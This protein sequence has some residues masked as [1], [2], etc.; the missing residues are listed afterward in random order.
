MAEEIIVK[1][2]PRSEQGSSAARRIRLEG[3]LPAVV[4]GEGKEAQSIVLNEHDFTQLLHHHA[5]EN[6]IITLKIGK[7]ADVKV[8]L[9]D[10]QHHPVSGNVMHADF[11]EISMTNKLQLA[12]PIELVGDPAGVKQQGG[13][14]EH[15]LRELEVECLPT[16]IVEQF[17][18]DVSELNIGDS[19]SVEDLDIDTTKFTVLTSSEIAVASVAA[20]RVE[21][22][23]EEEEGELEEGAEPEVIGEKKEDEEAEE[24][25]AKSEEG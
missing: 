8:L 9:K 17:H 23:E 7:D 1:A 4:Y 10:V 6:L 18:V 13:V 16:D 25:E 3:R 22:E 11:H 2:E 21:E 24:G 15:I 5:S 20:P 12:I 14:L 19:I